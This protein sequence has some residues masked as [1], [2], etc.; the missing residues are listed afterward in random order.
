[1]TSHSSRRY[2][3]IAE[4]SFDAYL[5]RLKAE[6]S[7][8]VAAAD[9]GTA[10]PAPAANAPRRPSYTGL[11]PSPGGGGVRVAPAPANGAASAASASPFATGA[12]PGGDPA[13]AG[14]DDDDSDDD[15]E[16]AGQSNGHGGAVSETGIMPELMVGGAAAGAASSAVNGA[17][18][19][20]A[21][22]ERCLEAL[23][24][25]LI[26]HLGVSGGHVDGQAPLSSTAADRLLRRLLEAY[27]PIY[28]S[29]AC[30]AALL[31]EDLG[32]YIMA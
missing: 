24:V 7:A 21:E 26:R 9:R 29:H 3:V 19:A 23:A 13:V 17:I 6:A 15:N 10:D 28:W 30:V 18:A 20:A 31:G 11:P 12:W 4:K 2:T 16:D 8:A 14:A 22:C 32:G 27:S 1:M 25:A 5:A